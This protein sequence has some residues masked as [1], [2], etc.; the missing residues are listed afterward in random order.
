MSHV[1]GFD[2]RDEFVAVHHR[3][4][5]RLAPRLVQCAI[6]SVADDVAERSVEPYDATTHL[7]RESQSVVRYAVIVLEPLGQH[8][9]AVTVH[10]YA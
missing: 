5:L 8:T 2:N 1:H 9:I 7:R 10:P 3:D 4:P 6:I